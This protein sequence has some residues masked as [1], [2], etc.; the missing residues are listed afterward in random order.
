MKTQPAKRIS[1]VISLYKKRLIYLAVLLIL[2]LLFY[3]LRNDR[4]VMNF[5]TDYVAYPIR[6]SLATLFSF[7]DWSVAEWM[8]V[9]AMAGAALFIV[10]L[11]VSLIRHRRQIPLVLFR[12]LT[13]GAAV[14]LTVIM[15][16]D[17]T[18]NVNYQ[19]DG[20]QQK[21]GVTA[22]EISVSELYTTTKLFAERLAADS[23]KVAR[24]GNGLYAEDTDAA[25]AASSTIY[26]GVEAKFPFLKGTE[27]RSK[28]V[29]FSRVM[30]RLKITGV[31]F[32]FTGEAN[33]NI[34]QPDAWI[35][36]TI[37]HE[38]AH[39]RKI[40]PE[41]DANFVAILACD[42]SGN[43]AY[44]YSGDLLAYG[45]LADALSGVDRAGYLEI[46][47]TL[48]AGVRADLKYNHDYWQQFNGRAAEMSDSVNDRFLKS[49]GQRMGTR[50]YGAVVDLLVAYYLK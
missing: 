45:Y 15:L 16:M 10:F 19:A 12:Y 20:F 6:S 5:M 29:L 3:L 11:A 38:I 18:W 13:F 42:L 43:N 17:L 25:F 37:A 46:E 22:R 32:P 27:L 24:D 33:I 21:S 23:T 34:H 49:N 26:R 28:K 4:V 44:R 8:V 47:Q 41:Q 14:V 36:A 48:P 39:Q 2:I 7:T 50:S 40:A 1:E 30:S 31:A 9:G 35:P